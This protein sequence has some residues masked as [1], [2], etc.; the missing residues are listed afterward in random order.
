MPV[1]DHFLVLPLVHHLDFQTQLHRSTLNLSRQHYHR[2]GM[3]VCSLRFHLLSWFRSFWRNVGHWAD[4]LMTIWVQGLHHS[5]LLHRHLHK[6]EKL[7]SD[8]HEIRSRSQR[9][10]LLTK[11]FVRTGIDQSRPDLLKNLVRKIEVFLPAKLAQDSDRSNST[12]WLTDKDY[13]S[14]VAAFVDSYPFA[15]PIS[16]LGSLNIEPRAIGSDALNFLLY[17]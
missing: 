8:C 5:C 1:S 2:L 10:R 3:L 12:S 9:I 15:A 13:W 7:G 14:E 4:L 16:P 17:C 6:S 11:V